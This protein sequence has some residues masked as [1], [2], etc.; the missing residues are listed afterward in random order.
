MIPIER[1]DLERTSLSIHDTEYAMCIKYLFLL[2]HLITHKIFATCLHN[3]ELYSFNILI[4][5]GGMLP[6]RDKTLVLQNWNLKSSTSTWGP[7]N[8]VEVTLL[9]GVIC[10]NKQEESELL[11]HREGRKNSVSVFS[12]IPLNTSISNIKNWWKI[13][14]NKKKKEGS[15]KIQ[16]G[17]SGHSPD[18]EPWTAESQRNIE[19][20]IE[21]RSHKYHLQPQNR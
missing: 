5:E 1:Q 2:F 9:T 3:F 6:P 4:P 7:W 8:K 12:G 11:Q 16:K 10:H 13:T 21:E 14:S 20:V 15:L 19:R 17:R 18:N